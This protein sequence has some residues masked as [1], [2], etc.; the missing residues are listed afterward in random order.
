MKQIPVITSKQ[1][2]VEKITII[3]KTEEESKP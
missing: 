3:G 2:P 1:I